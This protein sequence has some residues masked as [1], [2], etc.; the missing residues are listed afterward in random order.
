MKMQEL[1]KRIE[2]WNSVLEPINFPPLLL[3]DV[4]QDTYWKTC[5]VGTQE[6][7]IHISGSPDQC[8][9]RLNDTLIRMLVH[10]A[11]D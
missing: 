8:V 11:T 9:T 6:G 3:L 5:V 2:Y 1:I 7:S 4:S 10:L